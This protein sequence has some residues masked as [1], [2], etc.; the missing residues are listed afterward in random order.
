MLNLYLILIAIAALGVIALALIIPSY[1]K[2]SPTAEFLP[3]KSAHYSEIE[4]PSSPVET[5]IAA[6]TDP[7]LAA[8]SFS[9]LDTLLDAEPVAAPIVVQNDYR[10][11]AQQTIAANSEPVI[12]YLLA[13]PGRPFVGYELLQ[14]MLAVNLRFGEMN[15]FHRHS[16]ASGE[17]KILFSVASAVEPG[18]F[19]M[20]DIGGFSCPG[21]CLFMS[22]DQVEDPFATFELLLETVHQLADDLAGT[23]CD[24]QRQ[25]LTEYTLVRYRTALAAD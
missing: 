25:P 11:R 24:G 15:I 13:T 18:I 6:N 2:K 5:I 1:R 8:F 20:A 21:L 12:F 19:D 17:G 16:A 7:E 23:V 22:P 10:T 3:P 4:E 9:A 14:A